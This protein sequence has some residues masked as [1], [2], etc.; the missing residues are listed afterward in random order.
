MQLDG[1]WQDCL[2]ESAG[3]SV[4]ILMSCA[5]PAHSGAMTEWQVCW[6]LMKPRS[7]MVEK[8]AHL[9]DLATPGFC[10]YFP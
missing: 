4:Q 5:G 3:L 2:S 8:T 1:T 7:V 9:T 10:L 6:L